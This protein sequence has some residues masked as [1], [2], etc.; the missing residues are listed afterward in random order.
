MDVVNQDLHW[1]TGRVVAILLVA[2]AVAL[3]AGGAGGYLIKG[4]TTLARPVT[5]AAVQAPS[6]D[7]PADYFG[8]QRTSAGYIAGL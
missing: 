7:V 1:M 4:A 2:L 3:L 6:A 5:A 8:Q